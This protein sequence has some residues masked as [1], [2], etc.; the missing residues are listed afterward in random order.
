M[1]KRKI[2]TSS[3][4]KIWT[5]EIILKFL[6][7]YDQQKSCNNRPVDIFDTIAKKLEEN[8]NF[9]VRTI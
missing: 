5:N 7:L 1:S 2:R 8:H 6:E 3:V 4:G 9:K